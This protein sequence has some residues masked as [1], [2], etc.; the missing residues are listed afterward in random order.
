MTDRRVDPDPTVAR[1]ETPGQ[2]IVAHVDLCASPN[3]TRDRQLLLGEAV[4]VLGK[5]RQHS[6]VR[7]EKDG[8]I[9]YVS[10]SSIGAPVV[11]THLV[12]AAATHA[13]TG[14]SIKSADLANLS[15]GAKIR[16]IGATNGFVETN[17][18]HIP[19]QALTELPAPPLNPIETARLFFGTPYLWG[20]NTRAG[21]D[22]S[23]LVQAA[24]LA[25]GVPCPG[26][27]D[28]QEMQLGHPVSDN[29]YRP[30]DVIF[31][32]GHE[33][34]VTSATHMIHA[35][36]YHMCVVEEPILAAI[37]RISETGGGPVTAH[38]RL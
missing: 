26:D 1:S 10:S 36:A 17:L 15:F 37:N 32:K 4:T 12:T 38:K 22:C 2:I 9:G 31:W 18:G 19:K 14:P 27:S 34:L 3:G 25:A 13:Y 5:S 16:A 28:Q 23:G 30:G 7:A 6:Y 24:L 20:G 29:S 8:Y 35:N 33:A 21:I 11:H